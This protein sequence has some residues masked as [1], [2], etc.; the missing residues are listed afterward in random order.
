MALPREL[1]GIRAAKI[2]FEN[3]PGINPTWNTHDESKPIRI[4]RHDFI[5]TTGGNI[6]MQVGP[7]QTVLTTHGVTGAEFRA[8]S[9]VGA[10][11]LIGVNSNPAGKSSTAGLTAVRAFEANVEVKGTRTVSAD[12][13]AL[14]AFLDADSGVTVTKKKSVIVV[15]TPNVSG[16]NNF[17]DFETNTGCLTGNDTLSSAKETI[18][19]RVGSTVR[20]LQLYDT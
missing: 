8:R 10:G 11:A 18:R 4:A 7:N 3:R 5:R 14:R 13:C 15:A 6:G 16:W 20:F 19:I 1:V 2:R 17:V 12:V 9:T